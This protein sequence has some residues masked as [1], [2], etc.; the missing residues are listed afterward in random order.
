VAGAALVCLAS[1]LTA[2]SLGSGSGT[3]APAP[4]PGPAPP[5]TL[6]AVEGAVVEATLAPGERHVFPLDLDE[7]TYVEVHTDRP[8]GELGSHLFHPGVDPLAGS[9]EPY[10]SGERSVG[11]PGQVLWEVMQHTG[12]HHLRVDGQAGTDPV[13]YRLEIV[14]LRSANDRDRHRFDG[15]RLYELGQALEDFRRQEDALEQYVAAREHFE[16]GEYELGVV[17]MYRLEGALCSSLGQRDRARLAYEHMADRARGYGILNSEILA[18]TEL[19]GLEADA[20]EWERAHGYL[21]TARRRSREENDRQMEAMVDDHSCRVYQKQ[22]EMQ[23]AFESCLASLRAREE[24]G[25][26]TEMVSTLVSLG[27]ILSDRGEIAESRRHYLR[28]LEIFGRFPDAEREAVIHNDLALLYR[29]S[30]IPGTGVVAAVPLN[31]PG[32]KQWNRR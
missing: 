23:R 16:A 4:P 13:T 18:L 12:R 27:Q 30:S 25:L 26:E 19:A 21:A 29:C 31:G 14:H 9:G 32:W 8:T 17:T 1:A 11:R 3:P 24:L 7:G 6:E 20:I 5:P 10:V 28:A 15:M 22:G 2:C